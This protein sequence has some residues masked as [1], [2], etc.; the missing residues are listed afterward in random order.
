MAQAKQSVLYDVEIP[1]P[2]VDPTTGCATTGWMRAKPEVVPGNVVTERISATVTSPVCPSVSWHVTIAIIDNSPGFPVV[3][4]GGA[5]TG[6]ATA[7][8]GVRYATDG[9]PIPTVT[10]GASRVAMHVSWRGSNGVRGCVVNYWVVASY[11]DAYE[12]AVSACDDRVQFQ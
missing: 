6:S 3:Q 2:V 8:Q 4:T 1:F 5:G 11:A 9:T 10:R 12:A 7:S